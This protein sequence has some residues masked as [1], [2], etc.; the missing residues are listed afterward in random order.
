VRFLA[1]MKEKTMSTESTPTAETERPPVQSGF[2]IS[3]DWWA[4]ITALVLAALI[5][6]GIIQSVPW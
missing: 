3:L 6:L 4:V 2:K 1:H 5:L